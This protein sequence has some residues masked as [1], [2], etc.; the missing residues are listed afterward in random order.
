MEIFLPLMF[1]GG[2]AFFKVFNV[3][4]ALKVAFFENFDF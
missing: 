1:F 4:R 2:R 3:L